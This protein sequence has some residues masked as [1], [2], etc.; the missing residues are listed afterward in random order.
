M[1]LFFET[2]PEVQVVQDNPSKIRNLIRVLDNEFHILE[3]E[4]KYHKKLQIFENKEK[5]CRYLAQNFIC[6]RLVIKGQGLKYS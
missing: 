5:Q 1:K 6:S 2:Y 3:P 4:G